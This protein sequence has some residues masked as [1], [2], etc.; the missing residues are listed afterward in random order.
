MSGMMNPAKTINYCKTKLFL[1]FY[2]FKHQ[3]KN[4]HTGPIP[5]PASFTGLKKH[6][7]P[8]IL[9]SKKGLPKKLFLQGKA[10][11]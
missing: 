9:K 8:R 3:A 11:T 10:L 1:F 2:I 6:I 4:L 5:N 7:R